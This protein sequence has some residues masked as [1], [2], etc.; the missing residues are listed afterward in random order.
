MEN[1]VRAP[2]SIPETIC[3]GNGTGVSIPA[4][5]SGQRYQWRW[6][7]FSRFLYDEVEDLYIPEEV[8]NNFFK[9]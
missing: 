8:C 6:V 2:I 4:S 3:P 9:S 5:K 1:T 7:N